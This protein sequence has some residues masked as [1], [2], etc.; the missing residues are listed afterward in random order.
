ASMHDAL[1]PNLKLLNDRNAAW[2][3]LLGRL[4]PGVTVAQAT[5]ELEPLIKQAIIASAPGN[6]GQAF[7]DSKPKSFIGSGAKG[8][9]RV[10][11]TFQAPLF[12][13][14]I[15]VGLLLCI[16]CA[17]VA[18][19]LLARA[20]ARGRE[21]AV[22]LALGAARGRLVRQLLTESIVLALLGAAAGLLVAW[23]GS[24]AVLTVTAGATSAPPLDLGMDYRV[25]AFT[26]GVSFLAVILF[27]LV[28]ALRAS[29]VDLAS[30]MRGSAHAIAGS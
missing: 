11:A 13:L 27:G 19:L 28:P 29:R 22:R 6:Q 20:I 25:L 9:S 30:T 26:L 24:R 18:N 15:G 21:M 10:R 4:A 7:L 2:L 8:F 14:M 17:N 12:T 16:I 1:F 5:H 23:W 3:L